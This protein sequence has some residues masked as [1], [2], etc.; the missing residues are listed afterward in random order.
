MVFRTDAEFKPA[1]LSSTIL[2]S[3]MQS[4]GIEVPSRSS[5]SFGSSK[6]G[7]DDGE[8]SFIPTQHGFVHFPT[9]PRTEFQYQRSQ[10][11]PNALVAFARQNLPEACVPKNISGIEEENIC[12]TESEATVTPA[13]CSTANSFPETDRRTPHDAPAEST[14]PYTPITSTDTLFSVLQ[15]R[16]E[17]KLVP[18]PAFETELAPTKNTFLHFTDAS[19]I[20]VRRKALYRKQLTD[21]L[22]STAPLLCGGATEDLE[23]IMERDSAENI[24][25]LDNAMLCSVPSP[26][27]GNE[28]AM[29]TTANPK[30][31]AQKK[32]AKESG[33]KDSSEKRK[34]PVKFLCTFFV[35]IGESDAFP[36]RKKIIGPGGKNMK[37]IMSRCPEQAQA[38]IRLRGVGS[39]FIERETGKE[40]EEPLQL[41]LSI[42]ERQS[43]IR[44]K[45]DITAL[46]QKVYNEYFTTMGI[47]V[48]LQCVEHPHNPKYVEKS[49]YAFGITKKT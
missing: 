3:V 47:R 33:S 34:R 24:E 5:V 15:R 30:K 29:P 44:C 26:P 23:A 4:T 32:K 42:M 28:D 38:K 22:P 31:T 17:P 46:M 7:N 39:G 19:D 21:P 20:A 9:A 1:K 43:Y 40:S 48:T 11:D 36:V 37:C 27:A 49:P 12:R 13:V 8:R 10:T 2:L 18:F 14:F 6:T 16:E 35:G 25:Y 45:A 41:N